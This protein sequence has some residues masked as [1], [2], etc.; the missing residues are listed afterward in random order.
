MMISHP[1]AGQPAMLDMLVNLGD[2]NMI[3]M[4]EVLTLTIRDN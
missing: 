3:A 4:H 1:M 2:S